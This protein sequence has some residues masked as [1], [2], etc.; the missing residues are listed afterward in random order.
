[1]SNFG[2]NFSFLVPFLKILDLGYTLVPST[3]I[4]KPMSIRTNRYFSESIIDSVILHDHL[5]I[6]YI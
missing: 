6:G 3:F 1:M 4:K 5:T 2:V